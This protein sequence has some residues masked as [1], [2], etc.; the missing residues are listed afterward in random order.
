MD[1]CREEFEEWLK[2]EY[3]KQG[4]YIPTDELS[5]LYIDSLWQAWQAS[6]A[7]IKVDLP[8]VLDVVFGEASGGDGYYS[9]FNDGF[10]HAT[11]EVASILSEAGIKHD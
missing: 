6:R 1:K 3:D 11:N 5:Q 8:S 7:A 4:K 2:S 10:E 9:G